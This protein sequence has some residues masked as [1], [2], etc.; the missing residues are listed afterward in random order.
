MASFPSSVKSFTTR[1]D[2]SDTI[3]ASHVNDLQDEVNAVETALGTSLANVVSASGDTM[4][5]ALKIDVN[6]ATALVVEQDGVKDNVLVVD[7]STG[8]VYSE[9]SSELVLVS[10]GENF[11]VSTWMLGGIIGL[12]T[13]L[14]LLF[15]ILRETERV[16][17]RQSDPY[18]RAGCSAAL[19]SFLCVIVWGIFAGSF[20]LFPTG[21]YVWI[22]AGLAIG[23]GRIEETETVYSVDSARNPSS[24]EDLFP[25]FSE[26][27]SQPKRKP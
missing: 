19:V 26:G 27:D 15:A 20:G 1:N 12:F 21:Y 16:Y 22:F 9:A 8:L 4:T 23:I 11:F 18:L 10:D 5:G 13:F 24:D 17:R 3:M 6:S 7:T 14:F 2:V 25:G